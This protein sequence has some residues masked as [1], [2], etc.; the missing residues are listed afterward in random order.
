MKLVDLLENHDIPLIYQV[1]RQALEDDKHVMLARR[2]VDDNGFV[3]RP[4][5]EVSL[6]KRMLGYDMRVTWIHRTMVAGHPN[7]VDDILVDIEDDWTVSPHVGQDTGWDY[8]VL[9]HV[10]A[11]PDEFDL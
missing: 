9:H 4:V 5:R 3:F 8:L 6:V 10:T 11:N 7:V 1:L 2:S